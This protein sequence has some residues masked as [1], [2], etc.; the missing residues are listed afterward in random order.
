MFSIHL[1][2]MEFNNF[3]SNPFYVMF[4]L[5]LII[6]IVTLM[7]QVGRR[8]RQN[9][10][11][12]RQQEIAVR[13]AHEAEAER[14]R[15]M[16]TGYPKSKVLPPKTRAPMVDP[17]G[18][19]FTGNIQGI[20]AKWESEIHQI[21]RQIIGQID[22]K[23][24]ALQAITLDANRTANRL[25][26]LVEH[27]EQIAR[28]QIEWQQSQ[29]T[30]NAQNESVEHVLTVPETIISTTESVPVATPLA[31]VLKDLTDELEDVRRTIKQSTTFS[32]QSELAT[33][34]RM[35]EQPVETQATDSPSNFFSEVEML[36]NYGLE[37]PEIAR[38]LNISPG[39]VDLI[40][41]NPTKSVGRTM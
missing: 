22:S 7:S 36:A 28:Q 37:P 13:D 8:S 2:V 31:D 14:K 16:Q 40:L 41:H 33:I 9:T 3:Y 12:R 23:M 21:G 25:E 38:R 26:I 17:F 35:E 32:E 15:Q 29:I 27:L 34:L 5:G 11:K 39:E 10:V 6:V 30:Q 18:V 20:A 19:P 24:S 4:L 1:H